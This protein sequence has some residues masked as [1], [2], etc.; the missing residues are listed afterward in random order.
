MQKYSVIITAVSAKRMF[1]GFCSAYK[2]KKL[3]ARFVIMF[4]KNISI[5]NL[6]FLY[7][8]S[9]QKI[10]SITAVDNAVGNIE[11]KITKI[12]DNSDNISSVIQ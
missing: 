1:N 11:G 3:T 8:N 9:N 4:K 10:T 2:N 5:R 12:A 7:F 6:K